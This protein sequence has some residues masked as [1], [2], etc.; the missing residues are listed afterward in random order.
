MLFPTTVVGSLPRP[1]YVKD[2]LNLKTNNKC[3][4]INNSTY[5][6][7]KSDST[8]INMDI[9]DNKS[10]NVNNSTYINTLKN[11]RKYKKICDWY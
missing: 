10:V 9:I 1:E 6:K 4:N 8:D 11:G 3:E 2:L 5:I 7:N